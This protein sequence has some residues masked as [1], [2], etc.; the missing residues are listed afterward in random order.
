MSGTSTRRRSPPW[1][2][3]SGLLL[4][5]AA[6]VA[7]VVLLGLAWEQS[8]QIRS[9][10]AELSELR[11]DHGQLQGT[12]VA[13]EERLAAMEANSPA[14]QLASLQKA[15]E[16]SNDQEV[17]EELHLALAQVQEQIDGMQAALDALT[18]DATSGGSAVVSEAD[19]RPAEIR[20]LV[21]RQKQGHSLSCESSA[22]SMAAQY[23]GVALTEA[24]VLAALP[25]NDNPYLGFR[26]NVDGPPGSIIDYGVYAGPVAEILNNVGLQVRTI[27]GGLEGIRAA[28]ARGNPVIAWI[29]YDCQVSTP[30]TEVIGD[31]TV[32]LVPYQHAVVLTGYNQNGMWAN[33]PWDGQ[34]DFY[35]N[36]DLRRAMSY[37]DNMALE[38]AAP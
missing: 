15:L 22:A 18:G 17:H 34:E 6:L 11:R 29:T 30:T 7:A 24:E 20:L 25:R 2:V 8:K 33:D 26:G 14:E 35:S 1:I 23:H 36:G 21:A 10:R 28:L 5:A 12:T 9:L 31:Q 27:A 16:T 38:V 13:L 37:F 4:F 3:W 32:P 19:P